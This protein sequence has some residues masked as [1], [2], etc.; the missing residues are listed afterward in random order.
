[1]AVIIPKIELYICGLNSQCPKDADRMA[2]CV[3]PDQTP[4]GAVSVEQI[5]RVFGDN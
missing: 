5:R 2:N 3:D 1:M 4:S